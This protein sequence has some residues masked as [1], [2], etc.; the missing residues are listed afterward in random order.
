VT[1]VVE[2]TR[3][4]VDP[5]CDK[6]PV[7]REDVV[8]SLDGGQVRFEIAVALLETPV[9]QPT[10]QSGTRYPLGS[11]RLVEPTSL[12]LVEVDVRSIHTPE[13]YTTMRPAHR[14]G[15]SVER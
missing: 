7:T 12:L 15:T 5:A 13:T 4:L 3:T 6:I 14:L 9:Y 10:D 2:V 1:H 11:G 8:G